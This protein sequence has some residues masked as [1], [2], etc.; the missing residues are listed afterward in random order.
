MA[1]QNV[2][3]AKGLGDKVSELYFKDYSQAQIAK[4]LKLSESSVQRWLLANPQ[5]KELMKKCELVPSFPTKSTVMVEITQEMAKQKLGQLV[6]EAERNYNYFS[7]DATKDDSKAAYWFGQ[8]QS[9]VEKLLRASGQYERARRL[10]EREEPKKVVIEVIH[11]R[12][13]S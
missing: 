13:K 9:A 11:T 8:Y 1:R 4:E 12:S 5:V 3:D 6:G 2:I 10:A 7:D